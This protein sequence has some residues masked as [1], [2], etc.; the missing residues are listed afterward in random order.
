VL[1]YYIFY[2]IRWHFKNSFTCL[3]ICL[4]FCCVVV[5]R[6][7]V[8]SSHLWQQLHNRSTVSAWHQRPRLR[9]HQWS[10]IVLYLSLCLSQ[11]LIGS[12]Q[13]LIGSGR[14]MTCPLSVPG[15]RDRG[16][17][18]INE[19]CTWYRSTVSNWVRLTESSGSLNLC[20]RQHFA[21]AP[22]IQTGVNVLFLV[23]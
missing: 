8:V 19:V 3:L 9:T 11:S 20:Y 12:G 15:I 2:D 23:G 6:V 21:M 18:L 22:C 13:S 5:L 10:M 16:Y 7:C 17:V 1:I 14:S 4:M